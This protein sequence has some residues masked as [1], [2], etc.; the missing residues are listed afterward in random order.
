MGGDPAEAIRLEAKGVVFFLGIS[1][2]GCYKRQPTDMPG[3]VNTKERLS[4]VD[5]VHRCFPGGGDSILSIIC[6]ELV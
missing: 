5:V 3:P 6:W 1:A 2:L 4:G